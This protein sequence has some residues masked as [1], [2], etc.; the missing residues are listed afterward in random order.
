V[1]RDGMARIEGLQ[2][3]NFAATH[4]AE[5]DAIGPMT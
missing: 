1:D 4:F 3:I 5:D 2:Q